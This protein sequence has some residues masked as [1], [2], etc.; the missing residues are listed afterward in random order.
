[1][2]AHNWNLVGESLVRSDTSE[3]WQPD[4][5][6]SDVMLVVTR[7]GGHWERERERDSNT[8]E[9]VEISAPSQAGDDR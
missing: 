3:P 4:T 7:P 2:V 1:M 6:D 8:T 5:G 9:G